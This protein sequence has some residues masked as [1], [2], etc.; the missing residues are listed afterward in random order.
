MWIQRYQIYQLEPSRDVDLCERSCKLSRYADGHP[1]QMRPFPFRSRL[2]V[3][4]LIAHLC[5][6]IVDVAWDQPLLTPEATSDTD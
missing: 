6:D 1:Y 4:P 2:R 5:P 3:M